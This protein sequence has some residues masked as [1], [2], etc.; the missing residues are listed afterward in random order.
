M[1]SDFSG[2]C[3]VKADRVRELEWVGHLSGPAQADAT[4]KLLD[5]IIIDKKG[6]RRPRE[7]PQVSLPSMGLIGSLTLSKWSFITPNTSQPQHHDVL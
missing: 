4:Q 3:S 6:P 7:L 5:R 2:E 1:A